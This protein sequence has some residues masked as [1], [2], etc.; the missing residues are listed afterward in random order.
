MAGRRVAA[1]RRSWFTWMNHV[2]RADESWR[3]GDLPSRARSARPGAAFLGG[4]GPSGRLR[5]DV[6][7]VGRVPVVLVRVVRVPARVGAEVELEPLPV[8]GGHGALEV[9]A[10]VVDRLLA[11]A[12]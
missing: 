9:G 8:A 11:D 5:R 7:R 2:A 4:T 3:G 12:A 10:A 6:L 1:A